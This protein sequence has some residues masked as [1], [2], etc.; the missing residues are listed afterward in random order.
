[1][2]DHR[3]FA[4]VA[5]T[6]TSLLASLGFGC[7][8]GQPPPP[9]APEAEKPRRPAAVATTRQAAVA[10]LFYPKDRDVLSKTLDDLLAAAPTPAV[11]NLRALICPHAGYAYSGPVAASAYRT[12]A[13]REFR[14]VIILAASHYADFRGVSVPAS[15]AYETPLG[16][17]PISA[18]ARQLAKQSPFVLEP[19]CFVQR[20]PWAEM[21]AK[22]APAVGDDTP[23]TWEH[24]VEVQVPFLQK[25]LKNFDLLPVVFGDAN[26]EK[27][28]QA[29]AGIIDDRTLVIA[30]TDLSHYHPYAEAKALDQ[31]TVQWVCRMDFKALQAR[32]AVESACGRLPVLTL[33]HLAR[34][35]GWTPQLLDCRNSGDTS[36]D[37]RRV[38]G[39]AAIAFDAPAALP[40]QTPT[41]ATLSEAERRFL[42]ELA[43]NTLRSVVARGGL[44]VV[45]SDTVPAR[46]REPKG[47]FV[48]LTKDDELRGCIGNVTAG[49]PLYQAV[50]Q[51][52]ENAA[53]HDPRFPPVTADELGRIHIEISIL[54]EPQRLTFRSP[55][56]LL[57]QLHPPRDGVVLKIGGRGATFLP[58]VWDQILD[59]VE[60]LDRL[61]QKAGCPP[62]AW[63]GP[64]VT[65]ATYQVEAF[66]EPK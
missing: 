27:V 25:T 37:K 22:P 58:Q 4:F 36:G 32:E 45:S 1:M 18:W 3:R 15:G 17:V 21:S 65:V 47:C 5:M 13:G 63:R 55:E 12:L 64:D 51:N 49:D 56:D 16:T 35:K 8:G 33:M 26:P 31:Q 14:T 38:V 10:G 46:L 28:A 44:P 9:S 54:T 53:L 48:T 24:S 39:Y 50:M 43:R 52:A 20:P 59:K 41:P 23:E 29:L 61:A 19:K 11:T 2:F 34:L 40:L 60:F 30:S 57:S 62:S 42:L 7:G 66:A 6:T